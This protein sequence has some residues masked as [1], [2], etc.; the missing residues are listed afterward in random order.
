MHILFLAPQPFFQSRGT[1]IAERRLLEF[2]SSQGHV[3]DLLTYHEGQDIVIPNCRVI[4]IPALPGVR[5]IRPGFSLKKLA[6][7]I[8][9]FFRSIAIVRQQRYELVHAVE[10]AVFIAAVLRSV[11][12]IPFVYDMDSSLTLQLTRQRRWLR[13]VRSLLRACERLAVRQSLGVLTVCQSLVEMTRSYDRTKLVACVEDASLLTPGLPE[14][15]NSLRQRFH[16]TGPVAMYVGNLESYQG[17]DLMLNAFAIVRA[18]VPDVRLVV[19]GGTDS[20]IAGYRLLAE[21]LGVQDAVYFLGPQPLEMLGV[22]LRQADLLI[23]PRLVGVNTPMKIYSYLDSGV[24]VL[25][26]RLPT[27]T[28]VLDDEISMLAE[29]RAEPFAAGWLKLLR[30]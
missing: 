24:A 3:V 17:V 7:D 25:A 19:V 5:G 11:F 29:P 28:Q 6:C 8:V 13:P 9:M 23:S 12:R 14:R 20:Q 1:P 21:S 10:E 4:R 15:R 2:L 30:D 27:H 16:L 26:T 22:L 18:E